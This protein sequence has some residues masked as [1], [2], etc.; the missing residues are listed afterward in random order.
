MQRILLAYD[1]SAPARA[2]AAQARDVACHYGAE[3]I[4]L[5]VGQMVETG[6][7]AETPVVEVEEYERIAA[8][9][10]A[11]A[12][13]DGVTSRPLLRWGDPT[14]IILQVALEEK[15]DLIVMGHRGLSGIA[16]WFLG[17]VAKK[18]IDTAEVSVLVVR[19]PEA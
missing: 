9:G 14:L 4:A 13:G 6:Y 17:S 1:G 18:V 8:E 16:S 15:C 3:V 7:A 12:G 19:R 5:V 11:L 10:A 2:A